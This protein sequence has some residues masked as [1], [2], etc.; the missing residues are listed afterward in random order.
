[1]VAPVIRLPRPAER[2][3]RA[4]VANDTA[5]EAIAAARRLLDHDDPKVV[6][7]AVRMIFEFEKLR[8]RM[9]AKLGRDPLIDVFDEVLSP[10]PVTAAEPEPEP[11]GTPPADVEPAPQT[12]PQPHH[13]RRPPCPPAGG[14]G[15][16]RGVAEPTLSSFLPPRLTG[17]SPPCPRPTPIPHSSPTPPS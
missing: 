2:V 12:T 5:F 3:S 1:M 14:G 7:A 11:A 4:I 6:L 17:S 9:T 16:L 10:V 15:R 8:L 13:D